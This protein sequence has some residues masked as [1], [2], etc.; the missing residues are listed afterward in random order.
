LL[1]FLLGV[2]LDCRVLLALALTTAGSCVWGGHHLILN[3]PPPHPEPVEGW[4]ARAVFETLVV[5]QAHYEGLGYPSFP[6]LSLVSAP[7][8]P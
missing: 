1:V 5:R 3:Q 4:A 6:C 2:P 7:P 8:S